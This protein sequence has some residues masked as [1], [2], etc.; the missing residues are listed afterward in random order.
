MSTGTIA[1]VTVGSAEHARWF[2]ANPAKAWGERFYL[3]YAPLWMT[4]I[5]VVQHTD[6]YRGWRD[7]GH[8]LFSLALFL[9]LWVLPL[10][11]PSQADRG[12]PLAARYI[13]KINVWIWIPALGRKVAIGFHRSFP[14][15]ATRSAEL[16]RRGSLHQ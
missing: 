6:T 12:R 2:G 16:G 1:R 3:L 14:S 13:F 8:L 15:S 4:A 10:L 11:V 7:A 5:G 9:P